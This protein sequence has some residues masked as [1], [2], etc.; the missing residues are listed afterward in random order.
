MVQNYNRKSNIIDCTKSI[1]E[2]QECMTNEGYNERY[3]NK[4]IVKK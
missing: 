1:D 4:D 3:I 2:A